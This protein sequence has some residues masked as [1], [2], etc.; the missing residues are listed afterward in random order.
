MAMTMARTDPSTL[1]AAFIAQAH[2]I[3]LSEVVEDRAASPRNPVGN[4]M[5][6]TNPSGTRN[7][8][9]STK[10]YLKL[11]PTSA[12]NRPGR[13]NTS[14]SRAAMTRTMGS[15]PFSARASHRRKQAAGAA[16]E[17]QQENHD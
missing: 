5:P 1:A 6:M 8:P 15:Q 4:G 2:S 9:L 13:K 16:R 10:R 7:R 17:H 12:A 14:T 3:T 11:N